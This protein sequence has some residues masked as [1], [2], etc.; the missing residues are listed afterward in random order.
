[1]S[2]TVRASSTDHAAQTP[3]NG[4]LASAH[5]PAARRYLATTPPFDR[6]AKGWTRD[7]LA[8]LPG[9]ECGVGRA[10]LAG[11]CSGREPQPR[12]VGEQRDGGLGSGGS[13]LLGTVTPGTD[14]RN[15]KVAGDL[16]N[17]RFQAATLSPMDPKAEVPVDLLI[18]AY[19]GQRIRDDQEKGESFQ[20]QADRLGINK[21]TVV[22]LSGGG[23][24]DLGTLWHLAD[25]LADGS[26]DALAA[27][28]RHWWLQLSSERQHE[29]LSWAEHKDRRRARMRQDSP[30]LDTAQRAADEARKLRPSSH[31]AVAPDAASTRRRGKTARLR[32]SS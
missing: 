28:S 10:E 11:S 5:T 13:H 6:L 19:I 27:V 22:K 12:S 9:A 17:S 26:M 16:G 32:R 29:V 4:A 1:M 20:K 7:R 31:E 21:P 30:D 2:L 23:T 14:R 24:V 18:C 3:S 15:E 25:K 8:E